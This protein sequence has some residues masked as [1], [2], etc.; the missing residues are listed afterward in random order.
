MIQLS[1]VFWSL[2]CSWR[3]LCCRVSY[4]RRRSSCSDTHR[5]FRLYSKRPEKQRKTDAAPDK[6]YSVMNSFQ[7]LVFDLCLLLIHIIASGFIVVIKLYLK[8]VL[9]MARF[10]NWTRLQCS[11]GRFSVAW[12][13]WL[14]FYKQQSSH[15]FCIPEC[16][17]KHGDSSLPR[18]H[19]N[20]L[21]PLMVLWK[22]L[23]FCDTNKQLRST[24][25]T[26]PSNFS[27]F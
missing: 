13:Y 16:C 18:K 8:V 23:I 7:I 26:A 21:A 12:A 27:T 15:I 20:C 4:R 9:G 1:S 17:L 6:R 14:G 22:W 25:T 3:S 10:D 19:N 24:K 11:V 5:S 2:S